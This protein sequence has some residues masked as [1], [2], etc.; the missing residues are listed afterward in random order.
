MLWKT[1]KVFKD[2]FARYQ[3]L[4]EM[5][6]VK[7][8]SLLFCISSVWASL[9]KKR[10]KARWYCK[11]EN[12]GGQAAAMEQQACRWAVACS[13]SLPHGLTNGW[14]KTLLVM[15]GDGDRYLQPPPLLPISLPW[16]AGWVSQ[17]ASQPA[18]EVSR[19][20]RGREGLRYRSVGGGLAEGTAYLGIA[21]LKLS[22][23]G[24]VW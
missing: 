14:S 1:K 18:G 3:A 13:C 6:G 23:D 12:T 10:S 21:R 19:G 5:W 20:P 22:G 15:R 16:Q 8:C 2:L 24:S 4:E 17:R 9:K 11:A 7:A